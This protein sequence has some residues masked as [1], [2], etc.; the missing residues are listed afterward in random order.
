MQIS[1]FLGINNLTLMHKF[2]LYYGG[3]GPAIKYPYST[4]DYR[5][6]TCLNRSTINRNNV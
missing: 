5:H 6:D 3:F 4:S 1:D 2:E